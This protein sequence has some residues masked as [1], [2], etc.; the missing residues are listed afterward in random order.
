M[1]RE[2]FGSV[3]NLIVWRGLSI[4]LIADR[5]PETTT[6]SSSIASTVRLQCSDTALTNGRLYGE[7][8]EAIVWCSEKKKRENTMTSWFN[9]KGVLHKFFA[10]SSNVDV[11]EVEEQEPDHGQQGT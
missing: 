11:N 6:L 3:I 7:A 4:N 2:A 1:P 8:E 5:R 9:H 10:A